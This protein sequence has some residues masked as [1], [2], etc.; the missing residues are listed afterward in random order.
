MVCFC[1]NHINSRRNEKPKT[2]EGNRTRLRFLPNNIIINGKGG[3]GKREKGKRTIMTNQFSFVN[4][5]N[6]HTQKKS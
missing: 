3:R 6:H 5:M 4:P 1:T 2:R